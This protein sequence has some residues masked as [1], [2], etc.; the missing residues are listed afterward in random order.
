MVDP[1]KNISSCQQFIYWSQ[2]LSNIIREMPLPFK[3]NQN[4]K[5]QGWFPRGRLIELL[6]YHSSSVFL[7]HLTSLKENAR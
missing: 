1:V 7:S 3:H 5:E 4:K 6:Y 2:C